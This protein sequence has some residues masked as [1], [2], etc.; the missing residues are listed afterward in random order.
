MNAQ[1]HDGGRAPALSQRDPFGQ[2]MSRKPKSPRRARSA[3]WVVPAALL[4]F[5]AIPVAAGIVRLVELAGD[6]AIT[7]AN[8]RLF[9][10]PLPVVT[11]IVN[12]PV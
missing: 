6:A 11:H 7:P 3:T 8:A 12:P 1:V 10:S 2:P 5:G 9:A 4:L